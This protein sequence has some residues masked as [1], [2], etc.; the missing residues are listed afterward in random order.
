MTHPTT[1]N[2]T[3]AQSH[4]DPEHKPLIAS[5]G[6]A[7]VVAETVPAV[8]KS[9]AYQS[10]AQLEQE[11]IAQLE[12]QGYEYATQITDHV[13]MVANLR[14]QLEKVNK[15]QFTEDDWQRFYKTYIG[16]PASGIVEKTKFLQTDPRVQFVDETGHIKNITVLDKDNIHNNVLQV[17]N[18]YKTHDKTQGGKNNRYDVTVLVNG[19]P[20][21]HIELKRR[22]VA[23][24]E[25]FNQI[26][27]YSR[28]SFWADSGLF[29]YVQLFVISNGTHT[30]YYSNTTRFKHVKDNQSAADSASKN[31]AG[32]KKTSNSFEFTSWWADINNTAITDLIPFATTFFSKHTLLSILTRY[33][34]FTVDE[35]LLV[36]RPY[37]IAAAEKIL[38]RIEISTNYRQL[39]TVE[40]GGYIWHSTGSGKTL[41]SFKT[42]QLA[43]EF[44]SVDKVLFVVDRKDLDYQ[45]IRE[46]DR[47]QKGAAN[48]NTSTKI[49]TQQLSTTEELLEREAQGEKVNLAHAD[50]K[51][52]VTT[53]QK[54]NNFVEK[55]A[56]LDVFN[57]HVVFIFDECHRSQ[58][59][60]MH[61]AITKK[62][63][64]YNML[65]F[66]GT[67]I[68]EQ[69]ALAS[70]D[71]N[72]KTTKQAFGDCL[73]T[74]TVVDAIGDQ[75]VLR[76]KVEY[77]N[78]LPRMVDLET[79]ELVDLGDGG[80]GAKNRAAKEAEL[81][82]P[83]R[84]SEV[85]RYILEHFDQKT[86][87]VVG[88]GSKGA[89]YEHKVVTNVAAST[90]KRN[91]EKAIHEAKVLRGFNAMFAT[92][93]ID[94]A[95]AYYTE[96][97]AQQKDLDPAQRLKIAT[98]FSAGGE[99]DNVDSTIQDESFDAS[100]LSAPR[101]EFLQS[102]IDDYNEM[103]STNYVAKDSESFE[104]YY[105]DLSQRLKNR[106][107][108]LVIV[109]NM[110]LTGFDATTLNTL[111]VDKNLRQHGLIQAFS[112]TNRI[113]NSVKTFG[114]IVC[115]RDLDQAT[116]EALQLFGNAE[117]ARQVAILAPFSEFY[118]EYAEKVS[119]LKSKF[120]AGELII[121]ES[122]KTEFVKLFS[123]ILRLENIL[124]TFDEFEDQKLLTDRENQDYKSMYLDIYQE[125]KDARD[126]EQGEDDGGE[127]A[128]GSDEDSELEDA[129]LVFELELVKQVEI[130][131]D[132]ILL[133]IDQ[134]RESTSQGD[135]Q[136]ASDA[137]E[138]IINQ[139]EASPTLRPR[140]DLIFEFMDLG[141][142]DDLVLGE[143]SEPTGDKWV[144]FIDG[145]RSEELGLL[146]DSLKLQDA[147]TREFVAAALQD[148]GVVPTTGTEITKVLPRT[149][150]FGAKAQH[151][152]VKQNV[153]EELQAFVDRFYGL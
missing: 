18:Q 71:P 41:T 24:K 84:V 140:K 57:Q 55:N 149:S 90:R 134:M 36:M 17:I 96:F 113:L 92:A 39:G 131:V 79:G 99:N 108:D 122:G 70:G 31:P 2:T 107:V 59:G 58:F 145:K 34:V 86:K 33:C 25:A 147:A 144:K 49:L 62:F 11:F 143:N 20:M 132:Y 19:L 82:D 54:L 61:K 13:S 64:K 45:T 10:E 97:K 40:A 93:S 29:E 87:R 120:V 22:G 81:L 118:D 106:E 65:G 37:Q 111:F 7:T 150:R 68:F 136:A 60:S 83:A 78:V 14:A 43:T 133:L 67:P 80:G 125:F 32:K 72:L 139:V 4:S 69:N 151:S 9:T 128:E 8:Q 76:F 95:M 53:I 110:F 138:S 124:T 16:N 102:A 75:N 38:N 12:K 129:Q 130:N 89:A 77:H 15:Y 114:N 103:F 152:T 44:S 23:L 52:V 21:V 56:D 121:S 35:M 137:R 48:S 112:R 30:K 3:H 100:Q 148:D 73:H 141:G 46:Y 51:I 5:S 1:P 63:K 104:N 115:F 26:D 126:A 66:T 119:Q 50:S 47:F 105:K 85:T 109:V 91:V 135:D 116:N 123:E 98:I 146:I 101:L 74:Y 42:A 142:V 27:R 127:G 94:A 28:D 117:N 88:S 153:V 6:S